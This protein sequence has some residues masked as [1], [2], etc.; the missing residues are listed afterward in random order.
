MTERTFRLILGALLWAAL[1][2]SAYYNSMVPLFALAGLLAFEGITNWRIPVIL[3]R[4]RYGADY[5]KYLELP[6]CSARMFGK[7]ES[8]RV[9]RF[10]VIIFVLVPMY[11]L[12]DLIWFMPWFVAGML[13]LAGITNICPMV[14]FLRWSGLR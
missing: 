8:E 9:L 5:E 2:F 11:V 7:I 14:M 13:V 4:L 10:I 1:I 12:P 6:P 3:S